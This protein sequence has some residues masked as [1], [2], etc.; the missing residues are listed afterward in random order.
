MNTTCSWCLDDEEMYDDGTLCPV[1]QA[2]HIRI[3]A[4]ASVPNP[5]RHL[6]W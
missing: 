2:D 5:A 1:H 3:T 6:L 4:A